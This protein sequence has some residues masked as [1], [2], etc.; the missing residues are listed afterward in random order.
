MP[1]DKCGHTTPYAV[2][3]YYMIPTVW[4]CTPSRTASLDSMEILERPPPPPGPS[5]TLSS[6]LSCKLAAIREA[7]QKHKQVCQSL[8]LSTLLTMPV[9]LIAMRLL[10]QVKKPHVREGDD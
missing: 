2:F 1:S 3:M 8:S 7:N 5:K 9:L 4:V 6:P 10:A